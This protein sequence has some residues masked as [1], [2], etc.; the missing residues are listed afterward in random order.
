MIE[1]SCS[2]CDFLQISW[3]LI[4]ILL[5]AFIV[6]SAATLSFSVR[7]WSTVLRLPGFFRHCSSIWTP[8]FLGQCPFLATFLLFFL[9]SGFLLFSFPRVSFS[10]AFCASLKH[11]QWRT[12]ARQGL[13]AESTEMKGSRQALNYQT[14][15]TDTKL[16]LWICFDCFLFILYSFFVVLHRFHLVMLLLLLPCRSL[17]TLFLVAVNL[18]TDLVCL[19]VIIASPPHFSS[20][21]CILLTHSW[22]FVSVLTR[23]VVDIVLSLCTFSYC[24]RLLFLLS[25]P[26]HSLWFSFVFSSWSSSSLTFL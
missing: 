3:L 6:V 1:W 19:L 17:C 25:G 7:Y 11:K 16:Y 20:V 12:Q 21:L 8:F 10:T 14:D 22:V 24:F 2:I 23:F 15:V 5:L 26:L 18:H 4:L 9:L 13:K